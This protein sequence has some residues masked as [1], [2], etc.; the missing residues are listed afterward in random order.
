MA[1]TKNAPHTTQDGSKVPKVL[2]NFN[3]DK[4]V[5]THNVDVSKLIRIMNDMQTAYKHHHLW[6]G[7]PKQIVEAQKKILAKIQRDKKAKESAKSD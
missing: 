6:G 2:S 1:R 5:R 4:V 3:G 7:P